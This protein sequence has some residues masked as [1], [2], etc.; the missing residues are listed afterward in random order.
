MSRR[1][2][3]FY[4]KSSSAVLVREFDD[5]ATLSNLYSE[6]RGHGHARQL[7]GRI[8]RYAD[9]KELTIH[10]TAKRYGY[11]DNQSPD[12]KALEQFYME[13]GFSKE[14]DGSMVRYSRQ[15]HTL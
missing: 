11:S 14:P 12:N 15:K 3:K 1:V 8:C 4:H 2:E 10:L 9:D 7:M 5:H 13:F 6:D